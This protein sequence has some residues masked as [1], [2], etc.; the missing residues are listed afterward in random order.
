MRTCRLNMFEAIGKSMRR[1]LS[2]GTV[3]AEFAARAKLTHERP[4]WPSSWSTRAS[5]T[6]RIRT[7]QGHCCFPYSDSTVKPATSS[8]TLKKEA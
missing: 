8:S 3:A 4:R 7:D 2:P 6:L 5:K 1:R